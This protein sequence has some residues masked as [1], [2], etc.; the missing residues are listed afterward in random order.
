MLAGL[1]RA[2][3]K[4]ATVRGVCNGMTKALHERT[5]A[6][7]MKMRNIISPSVYVD[8]GVGAGL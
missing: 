2:E 4:E 1:V 6:T 7:T 8:C 5:E 3:L